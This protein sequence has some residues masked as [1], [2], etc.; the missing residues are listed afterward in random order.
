MAKSILKIHQL[1]AGYHGQ[2]CTP[3]ISLEIPAGERVGVLGSNGSGKSTLLKTLMGLLPPVKGSFEWD[4]KVHFSYAAQNGDIDSL[5]PFTVQDVLAMGCRP[6]FW[7]GLKPRGRRGKINEILSS[8]EMSGLEHQ[9]FR[10]LSGG[11]KQR[12]LLGR[13]LYSNPQVL[14][15]DEPFSS[16][17]HRFRPLVW[18]E[19]TNWIHRYQT[20]LIWIDHEL[21]QVIN[22]A[23][24]LLL[25]GGDQVFAGPTQEILTEEIFTQAYHVPLHLHRENGRYQ[26]HFI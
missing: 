3:S 11:L 2:A 9:L 7:R 23:T 13:A 18:K 6:D 10:E 12:T 15:L 17:D 19:L 5:F 24:Y 14:I 25:L 20:T 22:Q 16:L 8:L 1:Q 4:P 21:D 26:I